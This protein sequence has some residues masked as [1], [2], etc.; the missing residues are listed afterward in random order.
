MDKFGYSHGFKT[1]QELDDIA[2]FSKLNPVKPFDDGCAVAI[3]K[4]LTQTANVFQPVNAHGWR[5]SDIDVLE[6]TDDSRIANTIAKTLIPNVEP[7]HDGIDDDVLSDMVLPRNCNMSDV[8][9]MLN[10]ISEEQARIIAESTPIPVSSV[11][12][13]KTE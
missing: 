5:S 7:S 10:S 4:S 6:S 12:P 9:S 13:P 8:S 1:Q 2:K 11:E 3:A